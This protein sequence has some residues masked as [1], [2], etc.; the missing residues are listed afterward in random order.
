M[1]VPKFI[2]ID[3]FL[4]LFFLTF[5]VC[6]NLMLHLYSNVSEVEEL[7]EAW[8]P[9]LQA[10]VVRVLGSF[11]ED[12]WYTIRGRL[13]EYRM[14]GFKIFD[15]VHITLKTG[16]ND[17]WIIRALEGTIYSE[18]RMDLEQ[19]VKI[20]PPENMNC[21]KQIETSFLE[22]SADFLVTTD[23]I[24][25]VNGEYLEPN[26]NSFTFSFARTSEFFDKNKAFKAFCENSAHLSSD[27]EKAQT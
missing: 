17:R 10:Q 9:D 5:V 6:I 3:F 13:Q 22:F 19:N 24:I 15:H 8:E 11:G 26:D 20:T 1:V 16:D 25:I 18:G 7:Q 21:I 27:G 2:R 14:L 4:V 23:Q 12:N